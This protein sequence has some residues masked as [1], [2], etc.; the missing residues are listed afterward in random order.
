M[1]KDL[2]AVLGVDEKAGPEE[3]RRAYL[4][5]AVKYHPDRNPGDAAA[6]E[7]FKDLSQAYAILSDPAA[8]ARYERLRPRPADPPPDPKPGPAPRPKAK[9]RPQAAKASGRPEP[10]SAN[11]TAGG[12][13]SEPDPGPGEPEFDEILANFFRTAKG[14]ETLRD[15]EGELNRAGLKFSTG[16]FTR[17]LR[18][19]QP[20]AAEPDSLAAAAQPF[21]RRLTAWVPGGAAWTRRKAARYDLGYQ[22]A[23]APEAAAQGTTVEISYQRDG[24]PQRLKIRIPAGV[25]DGARLRLTGQGREKPDQSRGDLVL[26]VRVGRRPSVDDLWKI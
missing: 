6:E 11:S 8:R 9:A 13:H 23:L 26:T 2:H 19:K 10:G 1:P 20:P 12:A 25:K 5:L 24:V 7:R 22:L 17:W 4:R 16:D 21:L 3:L 14:R 18:A 15:L